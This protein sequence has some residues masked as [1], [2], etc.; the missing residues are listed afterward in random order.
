MR[1]EALCR[2]L[3]EVPPGSFI[4]MVMVSVLARR[5]GYRIVE[6]PVRH[7]PRRAGQQSLRGAAKWSRTGIRC[8]RELLALRLTTARR[9][10]RAPADVRDPLA[11][12][13]RD[14]TVQR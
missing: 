14:M 3:E 6:R 5:R 10:G 13:R 9:P 2:V 7:F 11:A 12:D 4:P 1:R 8:L